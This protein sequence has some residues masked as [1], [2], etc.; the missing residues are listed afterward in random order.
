[1]KKKLLYVFIFAILFFIAPNI[2]KAAELVGTGSCSYT[3]EKGELQSDQNGILTV[4][5]TDLYIN[6]SN[7]GKKVLLWYGTVED[8]YGYQYTGYKTFDYYSPI[9]NVGFTKSKISSSFMSLY[10][11][12]GKC[13]EKFVVSAS[14]ELTFIPKSEQVDWCGSDNSYCSVIGA[15]SS[16][17]VN[18]IY[19]DEVKWTSNWDCTNDLRAKVTLFFAASG[20]LQFTMETLKTS[21]SYKD[22]SPT[23]VTK[24][25]KLVNDSASTRYL[26]I[27]ELLETGKISATTFIRTDKGKEKYHIGEGGVATNTCDAKGGNQSAEEYNCATYSEVQA[28]VEAEFAKVKNAHNSIDTKLSKQIEKRI[29]PSS[30]AATPYYTVKDFSNL[31]K[32]Q[33][34]SYST[35]ID[36]YISGDNFE[37]TVTAFLNYLDDLKTKLCPSKA[38]VLDAYYSEINAYNSMHASALGAAAKAKEKL[39]ER[40]E[41]LGDAELA[42]QLNDDAEEITSDATELKERITTTLKEKKSQLE[43]KDLGFTITSSGGCGIISS[44]MKTFLNTILWYIRIAGVVLAIIL[45]MVDYIKAA[46][47]FDDK[48]MAAANKKML[49]RVILVAVLFLVPALL[50]FVLGL[51]NISTTAGSLACL[52]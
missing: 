15:Y 8:D 16:G 42:D 4:Y 24:D 43:G 39:A 34:T 37:S 19:T 41:E 23:P 50:E 21:S 47:S 13:P 38:G 32:A 17:S 52:K 49:T 44:D 12:T 29:P 9:L 35:T 18:K 7:A 20:K 51:L 6:S 5:W 10:E 11:S 40:A 27:K 25:V 2:T 3:M 31:T 30:S 28:E 14:K 33:V 22:A 48:S 45:S 26:Y 36:N 1:M 46:S